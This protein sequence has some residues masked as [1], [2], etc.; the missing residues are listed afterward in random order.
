MN[1]ASDVTQPDVETTNRV[2]VVDD[3]AAMAR[4]IRLTLISEG[5]AVTTAS[6][7]IDGLAKLE[8]G[9]YSLVVLDLQMPN[10]DGRQ[11]FTEMQR[12]GIEIPV[13]IVSAYGAEQA[14]EELKAAAAVRKPFDTA[15]LLELIQSLI[16]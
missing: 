3:D 4:M 10:M 15:V 7:G 5:Y 8:Q 14:R 12:R 11:M 13:V 16:L 6:D 2:L 9:I 1:T